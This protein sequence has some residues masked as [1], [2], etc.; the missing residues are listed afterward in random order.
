MIH[1]LIFCL[2]E[3]LFF[4]LL[5]KW[6]AT[7]QKATVNSKTI[8]DQCNTTMSYIAAKGHGNI[9]KVHNVN[10]DALYSLKR[11]IGEYKSSIQRTQEN[12]EKVCFDR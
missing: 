1:F 11:L 7:K 10:K 6:T 8:L 5:D 4:F 3:F 9:Q 12:K 2:Y